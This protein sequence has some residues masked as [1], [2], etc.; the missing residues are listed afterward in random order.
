MYEKENPSHYH[1]TPKV[2]FRLA[3]LPL[4]LLCDC[5]SPPVPEELVQPRVVSGHGFLEKSNFVELPVNDRD[6]VLLI[7]AIGST[8]TADGNTLVGVALGNGIVAVVNAM[9]RAVISQTTYSECIPSPVDLNSDGSFEGEC[10]PSVFDASGAFLW[11]IGRDRDDFVFSC[12]DGDMNGDGHIEFC[13]AGLSLLAC[14]DDS[15]EVLWNVET[16]DFLFAEVH[17]PFGDFHGG[18]ISSVGRVAGEQFV[19][20]EWRSM[21]GDLIHRT[22]ARYSSDFVVVNWPPNSDAPSLLVL[23]GK[24]LLL[25]DRDEETQWRYQYP[26]VAP[27]H[28]DATVVRLGSEGRPFLAVRLVHFPFNWRRSSLLIFSDNGELVYHEVL[29]EGQSMI[30][31]ELPGLF[32]NEQ[33]LLV[34]DGPGRISSLRRVGEPSSNLP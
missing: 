15:G 14:F 16:G 33:A 19:H 26:F 3:V 20:R 4:M 27:T 23:V 25:L 5:F 1:I 13:L 17:E 11:T 24:E 7:R 22:R 10:C 21:N 6:P 8:R 2:P 29:G 31:V 34:S 9:T 32:V 12:A 28:Y 30:A 18:V